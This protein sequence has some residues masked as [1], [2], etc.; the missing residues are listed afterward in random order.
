[1]RK[2]V[3]LLLVVSM[4]TCVIGCQDTKKQQDAAE[5]AKHAAEEAKV[6]AEKTADAIKEEGQKA[7]EATEHGFGVGLL[8]G[9][10]MVRAAPALRFAR[11][12]FGAGSRTDEARRRAFGRILGAS[13]QGKEAKSQRREQAGAEPPHFAEPNKPSLSARF[14]ARRRTIAHVVCR[15][16]SR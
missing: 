8:H 1:M 16:L 10:S 6:A 11:V 12:A 2:I 3:T 4:S 7:V 5:A 13:G 9:E 14:H 15:L